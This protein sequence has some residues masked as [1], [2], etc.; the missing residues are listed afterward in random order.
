VATYGRNFDFRVPPVGGQ[1]GSRYA[2]KAG[3]DPLPIGAP[4][5]VDTTASDASGRDQLQVTLATGDQVPT[6][7]LSGIAVFEYAPWPAFAGN[8]PYLTTYSDLDVVPKNS[9]LQL[10]SGDTVKVVFKNTID[11][12]FLHTRDYKGRV[13]V[14]GL[15][16]TPTVA[17]GDYLTPGT[18][19]DTAGYWA[20]TSDATK[21]WLVITHVDS[22][23]GEV[24]AKMAF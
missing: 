9:A 16:A 7:G 18:G 3:E 22:A 10:V 15:G 13:M 23:R 11:K 5:T 17:V 24:E 2:L 4:V 20:E 19:N 8:D 6:P 14:A 1:R 12:T 21:A